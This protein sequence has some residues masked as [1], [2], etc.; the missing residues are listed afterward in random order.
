MSYT[1]IWVSARPFL[2]S[3][4]H[5]GV[6]MCLFVRHSSENSNGEPTC[7]WCWCFYS[8]MPFFCFV[9]TAVLRVTYGKPAI[10]RQTN[11]PGGVSARWRLSCF[12]S[13]CLFWMWVSLTQNWRV[14]WIVVVVSVS[15]FSWFYIIFI[16]LFFL[17][18]LSASAPGWTTS[19]EEEKKAMFYSHLS[20]LCY[21]WFQME[22]GL[23][24]T[25]V[26]VPVVVEIWRF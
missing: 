6:L 5:V 25:Y 13:S 24:L 2:D 18:F 1:I 22:D 19:Y 10:N 17:F 7:D 3:Q 23:V 15:S 26:T 21:T 4:K 8:L 9:V 12:P 14:F 11:K 16:F 20:V